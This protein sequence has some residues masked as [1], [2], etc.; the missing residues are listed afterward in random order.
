MSLRML[1]VD[2]L[3]NT[4]VCQ[5]IELVKL[6]TIRA[7]AQMFEMTLKINPLLPTKGTILTLIGIDKEHTTPSISPLGKKQKVGPRKQIP[8]RK[9]QLQTR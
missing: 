9:I 8:N 2:R 6:G 3:H 4:S 7:I 5:G 1:A